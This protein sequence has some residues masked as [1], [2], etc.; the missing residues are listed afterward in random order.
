[1]YI[2]FQVSNKLCYVRGQQVNNPLG[3]LL[4]VVWQSSHKC[5]VPGIFLYCLASFEVPTGSFVV[6]ACM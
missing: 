6:Y 3:S 4:V 5:N 2:V 1:M